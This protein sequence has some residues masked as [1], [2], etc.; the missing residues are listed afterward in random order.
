MK[1]TRQWKP[2]EKKGQSSDVIFATWE[3]PRPVPTVHWQSV[4][5]VSQY[6]YIKHD[7]FYWIRRTTLNSYWVVLQIQ[8]DQHQPQQRN[9]MRRWIFFFEIFFHMNLM[10]HRFSCVAVPFNL[11]STDIFQW[12]Y[13]DKRKTK[14]TTRHKLMQRENIVHAHTHTLLSWRMIRKKRKK[15]RADCELNW[16]RVRY[17]CNR[18]LIIFI[19]WLIDWPEVKWFFINCASLETS[20]QIFNHNHV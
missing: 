14:I 12:T 6:L 5:Y 8:T 20:I 18:F 2:I 4:N 19:L 1:V 11:S 16:K 10:C 15:I 9:K 13:W 3:C 7:Y 17:S